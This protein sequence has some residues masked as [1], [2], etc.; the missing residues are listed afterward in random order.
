MRR[1][2][3]EDDSG[4]SA[5]RLLLRLLSSHFDHGEQGRAFERLQAFGVPT[6]TLFSI[7][8]RAAKE[9][10]SVVQGTETVFKPSDAMVLEIVRT[11][12]SRQF[13]VLSPMLYPGTLMTAVTPFVSVS[14]MWLAFEL[15]ATNMTPAIKGET[16]FSFT[17]PGGH[18][19]FSSTQPSSASAQQTRSRNT[20]QGTARNPYVMTVT[21]PHT[22]SDEDPFTTD[23]NHWPLEHFQEVYAV[24]TTFSTSDPPLWSPLLTANARLEALRSY[25]GQCLNC[26]GQDHKYEDMPEL[27]H[28]QYGCTQPRT[29]QAWR[30]RLRVSTMAAADA[31]L[32]P[33]PV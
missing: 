21:S 6:G 12:V 33:R 13:P 22:A 15:Y 11:S 14:A 24:S 30:R 16:F 20:H 29:W 7:F 4:P 17:S 5:F 10:V 28:Q 23:Y 32:S 31:L 26:G 1:H 18:T 8:L 19:T 27:L 3:L 9:L 25:S 2:L